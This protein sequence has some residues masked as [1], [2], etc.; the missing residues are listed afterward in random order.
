LATG[1][2]SGDDGAGE[3]EEEDGEEEGSGER[4]RFLVGLEKKKSK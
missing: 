4:L 3:E 1:E 2:V